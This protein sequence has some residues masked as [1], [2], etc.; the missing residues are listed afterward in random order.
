MAECTG[1]DL[2]F[3]R[4]SRDIARWKVA[5]AIHESESTIERWE[6]DKTKA[7]LDQIWRYC[8][9]I[10]E[11]F[12]LWYCWAR[13]NNESFRAYFPAITIQPLLQSL[14]SCQFEIDDFYKLIDQ[15]RRDA[16]DGKLDNAELKA[17]GIKELSEAIAAALAAFQLVKKA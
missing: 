5:E 3:A 13:S 2:Q 16:I 1:K 14:A 6:K 8:E 15:L 9:A 7:T 11:G 4:E 10:G 12:P 17:Q